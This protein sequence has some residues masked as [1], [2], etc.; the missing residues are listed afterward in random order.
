MTNK[1][2]VLIFILFSS[3]AFSQTKVSGVV[4]DKKK[5][6][7]A[8]ASV[9]FKGLPGGAITDDNGKFEVQIPQVSTTLIVSFAEFETKEIP[10]TQAETTDLVVILKEQEILKEV[11]IVGRP[12]RHLSKKENPAYRI[13]KGIWSH[14]KKNGL[15]LVKQYEYKKYSSVSIGLTNLDS[16]FLKRTLGKSYDS[17]SKIIER[18]KSTKKWVAPIYMKEINE[19]YYGDNTTKR[20][21]V[22]KLAERISGL[23]QSGFLFDRIDYTFNTIDVYENDIVILNKNFVS[24]ISE[25]GYGAYEYVLKDSIVD[26]NNRKIYDMYFFPRQNG[27]LV[28]EGNMKVADKT[29]A[30]TEISMRVNK[31]INLNLVRDILIEKNF[32]IE[33]DSIYLPQKEYY[34]GDFTALSKSDEERGLFVK[35][36][37]VYSDYDF[38]TK[39]DNAFYNDK[40]VQTRANQFLKD[41]AYWNKIDTKDTTLV[42]SRK[43]IG[44]LKN[45]PRIK[46]VT[47]VLNALTTGYF[48]VFKNVQFGSFWNAVSNNDIEGLRL[49]AGFRTFKTVDDLFRTNFYVAYGQKDKRYKFGAEVRYLLTQNPRLTAAV[50]HLEDNLQYGGTSLEINDLMTGNSTNVLINRGVNNYLSRVTRNTI[51]LNLAIRPN[52]RLYLSGISRKIRTASSEDFLIDYQYQGEELQN[53]INDFSTNLSLIYT[54]KR[55]INGYGVDQRFGQNLFPTLIVKYTRGM[56]GIL[57]SQFDYNK[58]QIGYN[59]PLLI[60]NFGVLNCY[61]E[62]GKTF[63]A[64]PLPLLSP[65][66]ANQSLTI[67][68]R[69]FALMDYFDM[70]TD[71]Y[72]MAH[73]DHHFNGFIFNRIPFL[74]KWNLREVVFYRGIYGSISDENVA[75]NRSNINYMAPNIKIYGEYGFGFENIGFGNFRPIRIDFIWRTKFANVNGKESPKFGVRVEFNPDF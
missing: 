56:K 53:R 41:D 57:E 11:V 14:R 36:N 62:A 26:E 45:S 35:K 33:N 30:L 15:S 43:I 21:K 34:E 22:D 16:L 12:K 24:P 52:I 60:S 8:F 40:V 61:L 64:L 49:R 48:D 37:I 31:G 17:I 28:F 3:L 75:I 65:V 7:V 42:A 6:P 50:S 20:V 69:T 27:D 1:I 71:S 9:S 18:K 63:E 29:F 66:P 54:P 23:G 70:I 67:V 19:A 4:L 44:K 59:K 46:K 72:T 55:I 2:G 5:Q 47:G 13:L 68:P 38:E 32:T 39:K 25:R 58:L 74:K 51:N 10:L 73:F